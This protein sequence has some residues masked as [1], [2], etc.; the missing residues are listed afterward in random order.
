MSL[1]VTALIILL[2]MLIPDYLVRI[3]GKLI[4]GQLLF[5]KLKRT[6]H[7]YIHP[8]K[9]LKGVVG[10]VHP[11]TLRISRVIGQK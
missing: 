2:L 4:A 11:Q 1:H 6:I 8:G 7:S 5:A 9:K 3:L 10:V